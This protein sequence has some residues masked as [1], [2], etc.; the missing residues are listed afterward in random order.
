MMWGMGILGFM[1][2][3]VFW[4]AII[5]LVVWA[6][7]RSTRDRNGHSTPEETPLEIAQ[8]RLARGE[9]TKEQYEEMDRVLRS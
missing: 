6:V 9:I 5:W 4:G 3:I 1:V 2:M 7:R 8:K